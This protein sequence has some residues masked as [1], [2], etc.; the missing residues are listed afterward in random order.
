MKRNKLGES[1]FRSGPY[2]TD[3]VVWKLLKLTDKYN[4]GDWISRVKCCYV[5]TLNLNSKPEYLK[6]ATLAI[7]DYICK[8]SGCENVN[9]WKIFAKET[10][11]REISLK[12]AKFSRNFVKMKTYRLNSSLCLL[13][14]S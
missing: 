11:S 8:I 7:N 3:L 4:I 6:K 1:S 12:Y 2:S 13:L 5:R 14:L 10:E 9:V